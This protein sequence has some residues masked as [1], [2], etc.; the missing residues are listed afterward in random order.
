[1]TIALHR[2]FTYGQDLLKKHVLFRMD[3]GDAKIEPTKRI[4]QKVLEEF[5]GV[6]KEARTN[7]YV[8]T[9]KRLTH[10]DHKRMLYV[11]EQIVSM[12]DVYFAVEF[13]VM[14]FGN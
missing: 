8:G 6:L 7:F 10:W 1:M 9:D 2:A 4:M 11:V 12:F 5:H 13:Q 3:N 14:G